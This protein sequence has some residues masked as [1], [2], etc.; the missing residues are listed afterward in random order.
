MLPNLP[1]LKGDIQNLLTRYL[2]KQ[3]NVR[4]GV[5]N[6]AP[7]HTAREGN[8]MRVIRG[9][10]AVDDSEFQ[11]SSAEMRISIEDGPKLS[12]EERISKINIVADEMASQI[13]RHAFGRLKE[14]VDKVGNVVD[15]KGQPFSADAVFEMLEKIELEFDDTGKHLKLSIVLSPDVMPRAKEVFKQIETDS[16]LRKRYEE[17]IE[18]KRIEWRDREA[19]RKLVG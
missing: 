15:S 13:S 4:L 17:I 9:D 7:K 14:A 10:G 8:R 12:I 18:K 11:E 3:I 19:S 2:Q 1:R 5:F 16:T 6:E